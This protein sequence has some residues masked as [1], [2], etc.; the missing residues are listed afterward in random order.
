[1]GENGANLPHIFAVI[2]E[3]VMQETLETDSDVYKRLLNIVRQVQ[4][5]ICLISSYPQTF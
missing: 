4:V 1:M 5:I 2:A 3:T